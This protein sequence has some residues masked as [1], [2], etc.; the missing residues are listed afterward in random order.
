MKSS[1]F[2]AFQKTLPVLMG[3]IPM[4]MAFGILLERLAYPWWLTP[5]MSILIYAG[6][7]QFLAVSFF[8]AN[9]A[10]PEVAVATFFLNSRHLFYG[11]SL[12][13][14]FAGLGSLK[15]YMIFA[16]TDETYGLLT[17]SPLHEEKPT[18]LLLFLTAFLNHLYWITGG[19]LGMLLSRFLTFNLTGLGFSL[20]ALFVV[21]ALEQYL[22]KKQFLPFAVAAFTGIFALIF[23]SPSKMLLFSIPAALFLMILI[24]RFVIHDES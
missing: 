5:L 4:G 13:K 8:A 16:L 10:L 14:P 1:F 12:L 7:A 9:A 21:L 15:F 19:V 22:A 17:A 2:S 23:V 20:T 3:Y 18:R 24:Q 11:L 6:A